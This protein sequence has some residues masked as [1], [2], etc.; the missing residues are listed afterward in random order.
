MHC[1]ALH[2]SALQCTALHK[3]TEDTSY[4]EFLWNFMALSKWGRSVPWGNIGC[5]TAAWR[6]DIRIQEHIFASELGVA[7]S[8]SPDM[9][10]IVWVVLC[11]SGVYGSALIW[12]TAQC[13]AAQWCVVEFSAVWC[14]SVQCIA[15]QVSTV[16][17]SSV[18]CSTVLFS[19]VHT[20]ALHLDNTPFVINIFF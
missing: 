8:S 5:N 10:H 9:Q 18:E 11:S 7:P 1:T 15:V 13:S 4:C 19:A 12:S 3:T 14:N 17:L 6:E 20:T 16:K 2:C